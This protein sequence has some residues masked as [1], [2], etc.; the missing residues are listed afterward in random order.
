MMYK[1]IKFL[2]YIFDLKNRNNFQ[3]TLA[4]IEMKSIFKALCS[5]YKQKRATNGSSFFVYRKT[6]MRLK[7][8]KWSAG[9][10]P[11]KF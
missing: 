10:A 5:F 2:F 4:Q 3:N 6:Q 8:L 9:K 11:N 7:I 1:K